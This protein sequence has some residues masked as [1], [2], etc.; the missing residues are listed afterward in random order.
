MTTIVADP[1][2]SGWTA[3]A[4]LS[5]ESVGIIGLWDSDLVASAVDA[6]ETE[7]GIDVG[8]EQVS[9]SEIRT[10][11]EGANPPDLAFL[12]QQG[13]GAELFTNGTVADISEELGSVWLERFPA[14]W[15]ELMQEDNSEFGVWIATSVKSVV[16]Y[17]KPYFDANNYE[18]P[19]TWAELE[20]LMDDM[21]GNGDVPWSVGIESGDA[22]GWV[23]TDLIEDIILRQSGTTVYDQWVAGEVA[24]SSTEIQQ[25]FETLD[26]L[27]FGNADYL[28]QDRAEVVS[29][30]FSD[31]PDPLFE[32]P[33]PTA[34]MHRQATFVTGFLPDDTEI[35]TDVGYFLLPPMGSADSENPLVIAGDYLVASNTDPAT[36]ALMRYMTEADPVVTIISATGNLSPNTEVASSDYG[37]SW[38][39]DLAAELAS[40][41]AVRFD[42]S[43]LMP[44]AVGSD[45][46]FTEVTEWVAGNQDL[47]TTLTNI[48]AAWSN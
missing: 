1:N 33:N 28:L 30:S 31:A 13:L 34:L 38:K 18:V 12:P 11:L 35:G 7:T 9:N 27:W 36:L 26:S 37:E 20:A 19:D 40:A 17:A 22:D 5:G 10:R 2:H 44:F 29:T 4:D 3:E 24:F 21:V 15:R 39:A 14:S 16:W 41:D 43:D 42:G 8:Y 6:F 32:T 48:D 47:S 46:F 23:A 25:A 45:A